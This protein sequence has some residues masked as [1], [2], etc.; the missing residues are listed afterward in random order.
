MATSFACDPCC[1]CCAGGQ[2][3]ACAACSGS[4]DTTITISSVPAGPT[5]FAGSRTVRPCIGTNCTSKVDPNARVHIRVVNTSGVPIQVAFSFRVTVTSPCVVVGVF[6]CNFA[7]AASYANGTQAWFVVCVPV[8]G[9]ADVCMDHYLGSDLDPCCGRTATID[10][11]TYTAA[12]AGAGDVCFTS[13]PGECCGGTGGSTGFNPGCAA[14][15][16]QT[17]MTPCSTN[18]DCAGFIGTC[19]TYNC[20]NCPS[21]TAYYLVTSTICAGVMGCQGSGAFNCCVP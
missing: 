16:N 4:P 19:S 10:N 14:A 8:D 5:G 6:N 11:F 15:S 18:A 17:L 1:Q 21:G 7:G 9:T 3:V 20:A 2:C 12:Q 13:N